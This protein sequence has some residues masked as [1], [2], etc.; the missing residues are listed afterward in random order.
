MLKTSSTHERRSIPPAW[1][2]NAIRSL[3]LYLTHF[4]SRKL[5]RVNPMRPFSYN[6]FP[7]CYLIVICVRYWPQ[8][9]D[10]VRKD[11]IE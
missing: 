6:L 3:P 7:L 10:H 1:P 8:D 11:I 9:Y 2:E 4:H 5:L